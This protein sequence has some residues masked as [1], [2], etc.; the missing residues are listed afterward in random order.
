[1]I[2]CARAAVPTRLGT[3]ALVAVLAACQPASAPPA[4]PESGPGA[5]VDPASPAA[6]GT[7][8]APA[9]PAAAANPAKALVGTWRQ[10]CLTYIPGDGASDITY[11]IDQTAPD[12]LA[13]EGVAK[14]YKNTSCAG[15][16]VVIARP[17]FEQTIVG[18]GSID[19]VQVIRLVDVDA[20]NPAPASAKSVLGIDHG[21]LRM[22]NANGARDADGY[23]SAFEAPTSAYK[24][25]SP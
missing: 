11:S 9:A 16:G 21:E 24:N 2:D 8:V 4:S 14:D 10:H 5:A 3:F 6:V 22:G 7:T 25:V 1:M 15:E 18:T 20:P 23:P 17:K 19:G 12:R 13:L